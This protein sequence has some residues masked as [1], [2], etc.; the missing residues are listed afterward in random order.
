MMKLPV[1]L[2]VLMLAV[3]W[4]H[5]YATTEG[6]NDMTYI[7]SFENLLEVYT[8]QGLLAIH[9]QDTVKLGISWIHEL[10]V[11]LLI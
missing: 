8:N 6:T 9:V 1:I 11:Q 10:W 2:L 7:F 3:Y 4:D 5:Y